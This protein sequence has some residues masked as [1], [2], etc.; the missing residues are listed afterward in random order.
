MKNKTFWFILL[1]FGI[2]VILCSIF[3]WLNI[4]TNGI[5]F[6]G[7]LLFVIKGIYELKKGVLK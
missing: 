5:A 3:I 7:G 2:I 1:S 6:L 4:F